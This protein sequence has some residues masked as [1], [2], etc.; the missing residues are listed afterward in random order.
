[1]NPPICEGRLEYQPT[2]CP[3]LFIPVAIVAA[4][5]G[6]SIVLYASPCLRNPWTSEGVE[7]KYAPTIR[8]ASL[9][10]FGSV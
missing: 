5:L 9:T 4:A 3:E 2:I 1:M 10:S 6:T 8:P 7:S